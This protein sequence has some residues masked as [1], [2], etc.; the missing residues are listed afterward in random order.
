MAN[1][2]VII[3]GSPRKRGNTARMIESFKARAEEGG[4][5]VVVFDAATAV[6]GGCRACDTCFESGRACTYDDDFNVI[7]PDILEA[8]G[9]VIACPTYWY[10]FPGQIKNAIDKLYSFCVGRRDVAKKKC[11]LIC[12]CEEDELDVMDGISKPLDRIAALLEWEVVGKV[13]VPGVLEEGAVE[14]TDGRDRAAAL[15]EKFCAEG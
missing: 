6:I 8:D 11:G 1:K 3:N 4:S 2:I 13:L 5:T 12:C 10:S 14:R 9:V 7:A 15:A